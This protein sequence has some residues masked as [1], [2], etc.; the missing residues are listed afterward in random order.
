MS[1]SLPT[2]TPATPRVGSIDAFRALVML[3]M[4]FVN[5]IA[6]VPKSIVPWWMRHF[7]PRGNGM[8]FVDLVFP[9]FLFIV[10]MSVPF[11]LGSRLSKGEPL[12][13]TLIHIITRTLS[14]LSIGILMVNETPDS[15]KMGWSGA[16]WC[17]L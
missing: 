11:A 10:G 6:G 17:S 7:E 4:I 15:A 9:G 14:L 8:T 12:W 2:T 13:K 3:T 16:L 5:D 1:D